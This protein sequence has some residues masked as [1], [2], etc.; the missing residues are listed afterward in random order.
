MRGVLSLVTALLL[1][2]QWGCTLDR[3]PIRRVPPTPIQGCFERPD[4]R[5]RIV[6]FRQQLSDL[7]R[8]TGSGIDASLDPTWSFTGRLWSAEMATITTERPGGGLRELNLSYFDESTL[9][10][11]REGLRP[12]DPPVT[13]MRCAP[14]SP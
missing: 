2:G 10:V 11:T 14:G 3:S 7:L 4:T 9:S 12:L 1:A 6:I 5:D 13:L 8:G